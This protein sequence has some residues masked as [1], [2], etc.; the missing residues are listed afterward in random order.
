MSYGALLRYKEVKISGIPSSSKFGFAQVEWLDKK[1]HPDAFHPVGRTT[2]GGQ[3][4]RS[5]ARI[6]RDI[7]G[8]SNFYEATCV[9][10]R[11]ITIFEG[12]SSVVTQLAPTSD[13]I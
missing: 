2:R 8:W 3:P 10:E 1:K 4:V 13:L 6:N 11:W 9:W 5:A 7:V 12:V